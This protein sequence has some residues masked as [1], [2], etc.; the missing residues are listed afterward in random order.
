MPK[1]PNILWICTDQQRFD[2]IRALGNSS[3]RTP[4]L[5]RFIGEG[6]AFENAFCQSP[7]CAPSRA[8][9]L[10]GR[11]PRTTRCRQNGQSIPS[12]EVLVTKLFAE[13]G[14]HCGLAGKLHLAS[15][16]DG[17]VEDRTDDGYEDFHWSHHPQ[18]DWPENAY[19]QWLA[20]KGKTWEDVYGGEI[21]PYVL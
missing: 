18:P 5:D 3:A 4:N 15:C 8:S 1:R 17:K 12:D 14:Y 13:A 11:Y 2:T 21:S 20:E 16:S 19:T 9:F 7:V 6:V 10:T